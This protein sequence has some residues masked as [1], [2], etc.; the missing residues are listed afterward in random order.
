VLEAEA[1]LPERLTAGTG[2]IGIRLA[3]HNV[4][5]ALVE[6][7]GKTD[8]RD[9]RQPVRRHRLPADSRTG[10]PDPAAGGPHS[11]RRPLKGGVGSTVVD[12]TGAAPVVIR[13]GKSRG[14]K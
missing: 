12:V 11:R 6:A 4:A 8:H 9:Q 14:M 13:E 3:A 5:R 10:P 1:N 2:K 7:V